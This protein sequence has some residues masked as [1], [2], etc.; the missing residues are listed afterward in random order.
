LTG[1]SVPIGRLGTVFISYE[2]LRRKEGTRRKVVLSRR[3]TGAEA[4]AEVAPTKA[5]GLHQE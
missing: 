1:F 3:P 5:L 2:V 4:K